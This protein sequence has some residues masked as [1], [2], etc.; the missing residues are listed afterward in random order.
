MV[1]SI[2]SSVIAV[3]QV[4][5]SITWATTAHPSVST[6]QE[7]LQVGRASLV[8]LSQLIHHLTLG[9]SFVPEPV[10][11]PPLEM[12]HFCGPPIMLEGPLKFFVVTLSVWG[13][14]CMDGWMDVGCLSTKSINLCF[15][16]E[17]AV[18]VFRKT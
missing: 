17:N 2:I 16:K 12:F 8:K 15:S 6:F 18:T 9:P 10:S 5:M 11:P 4:F 7:F 1:L 14:V 3:Q 13:D